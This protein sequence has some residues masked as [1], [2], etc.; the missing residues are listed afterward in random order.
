MWP[1]WYKTLLS[2]LIEHPCNDWNTYFTALCSSM[3]PVCYTMIYCWACRYISLC[4]SRIL[5]MNSHTWKICILHARLSLSDFATCLLS[6]RLKTEFNLWVAIC[7]HTRYN[8]MTLCEHWVIDAFTRGGSL[9]DTYYISCWRGVASGTLTCDVP[10]ANTRIIIVRL[11][12]S[13][14]WLID[15]FTRGVSL[16]DTNYT[17]CRRGVPSGTEATLLAS[18]PT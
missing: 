8:R 9:W 13:T 17:S 16:L 12:V 5:Y 1:H 14:D 3:Q 2:A 10:Y 11:P 7:K 18:V 15:A 4:K 6:L